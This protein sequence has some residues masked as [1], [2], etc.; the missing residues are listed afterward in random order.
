MR[1]RGQVRAVVPQGP[2]GHAVPGTDGPDGGVGAGR[3]A[4]GLRGHAY[5]VVRAAVGV[6]HPVDT[7]PRGAD[8]RVDRVRAGQGGDGLRVDATP[9]GRAG[10]QEEGQAGE[11]AFSRPRHRCS[12]APVGKRREEKRREDI[13]VKVV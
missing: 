9:Q 12:L 1:L 7:R 5:V 6:P 3:H 13:K 2:D 10:D 8:K 11:T 4:D